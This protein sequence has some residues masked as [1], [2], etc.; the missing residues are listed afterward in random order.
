[1]LPADEYEKIYRA[2]GRAAA[3]AEFNRQMR[4]EDLKLIG[5]FIVLGVLIA[6]AYAV[7]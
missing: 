4:G 6:L 7:S 1:M 3:D 5:A 2:R